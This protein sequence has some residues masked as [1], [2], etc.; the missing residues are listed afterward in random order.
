MQ[1]IIKTLF[2]AALCAASF[3]LQAQTLT[4]KAD[5]HY[6]LHAYRLAAQNYETI[7]ARDPDETLVANKLADAYYHLNELPKAA[8]WYAVALRSNAIKP[9]STLQYGKV[10]MMLGKYDDA[11]V[12][13]KK[14]RDTNSA[15]AEN[16]IKACQFA[17]ETEDNMPDMTVASVAKVNTAASDFGASMMGDKL[18]WSSSRTDLKRG[19]TAAKDW[20]GAESN[21]L[22]SAAIEGVSTQPFKIGFLKSDFKNGMNESHA[23]FSA[24]GKTVAFMR[25]NLDDGERIS[26]SGGMELSIFTAYVDAQ[27]NWKDVKAFPYNGTGF[28]SGF[29]ALSP[30]GKTLYFAS[31]RPGGQGGYDIYTCQK[32]GDMW[33]EPRNLGSTINSASDEITPFT[34]GKTLYFA[35]DYHIGYGGFDIFKTEG[36]GSE[37]VNLG[38]GINSAGDDYGFV[39][40]PSV[41]VGFFTSNRAGGKGK[42]DIYRVEKPS[43]I[44]NIVVLD[45]GMPIKNAKISVLQGNAQNLSQLKSGN[46]L[47]D[48]NDKKVYTIEV[49]K[50]GFKTK[51]VKIE[52]EFIKKSRVIEVK[53]ERDVPIEMGIASVKGGAESMPE[54]KGRVYDASNEDGLEGVL[55]RAT[56]QANNVQ[57]ETLSDKNGRFKF[58]LSPSQTYLITY[59]KEEFV[60]GKKTIK[61]AD[62]KT[63][64]IGEYSMIPSAVTDKNALIASVDPVKPA[65][66]RP[67]AV[68]NDYGKVVTVKS[69]EAPVYAVQ[70]LVTGSDN[71]L[72]LSQYDEL[73][74]VGNIYIVPEGGNQKIRLGIYTSPAEAEAAMKKVADLGF[75]STYIVQEKNAKAVQN[76]IFTPLPKPKTQPKAVDAPKKTDGPKPLPRPIKKG[77]V[78]PKSYSNETVKKVVEDKTFKVQI[79]AMKNPDL[80]NDSKVGQ[81]WKIDQVKHG[82]FTIFI[83]DGIKTLQQAKDL[84]AKVKTAGFTDAK[85]VVKDGEKF[86]V[87]D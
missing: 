36:I 14:Y 62:L 80:F 54:Y 75:K 47:L 57:L 31:N 12:Q 44:A 17:K 77:E 49:K 52:P 45:N 38:T 15:V 66:S 82:E 27:G 87:V 67:T 16:Y 70:L 86:K 26:S 33:A 23:S 69:T 1:F 81:I 65:P 34:D 64:I 37:I 78:V 29:P 5:M 41:K 46:W 21:Q 22:F 60:I 32:R 42:E 19:E 85:V 39:F 53:L 71:V 28:S 79:A 13:F 83:M 6:E 35:S 63:K 25:N 7:L 61:A 55:V 3:A 30:D 74:T 76:N 73:K 58:N 24:D 18:I 50:E 56:N 20:S 59:S 40:D 48:L 4:E 2:S 43:E 8:K 10:L 84:K 68:P 51:T 72:N 9:Q 11:A